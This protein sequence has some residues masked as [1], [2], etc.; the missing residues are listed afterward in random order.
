M[1]PTKARRVEPN[2]SFWEDVSERVRVW[3]IV[4]LLT[5]PILLTM[6]YLLPMTIQQ[7]LV[8]EY[9]SPSLLNL[10]TAAYVHRGYA[11]FSNNLIAYLLFIVPTYLL[12][13]LADERQLFRWAFLSFLFV[14]P[15]VLAL[16]NIVVIGQ[17]TGAGFSGIGAAYMGLL[18]VS[19]FA[20]IRSRISSEIGPSNGVAL[21]LMA[22]GITASIYVDLFAAAGIVALSGLLLVF[23]IHR[24]GFYEVRRTV[25]KLRS[26]NG[27]FGL[28]LAAG[29]LFLYSPVV[30]FPQEIAQNGNFVNIVSHY[31]GLVLGFFGPTTLSIYWK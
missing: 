25:A 27:Y 2:N 18:P 14:L 31:M 1:K 21:F 3:D 8:L 5:V 28:V 30:L 4:L 13:V 11:H 6:V 20:F 29:L 7:S 16:I 24:L 17:G 22:L 26:M 23:D 9:G 15:A 12:F 10:W 19:M